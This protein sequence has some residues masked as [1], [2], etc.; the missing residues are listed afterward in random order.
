MSVF[1]LQG[2]AAIELQIGWHENRLLLSKVKNCGHSLTLHETKQRQWCS[3]VYICVRISLL[4]D[5]MAMSEFY[6]WIILQAANCFLDGFRLKVCTKLNAKLS[7]QFIWLLDLVCDANLSNNIYKMNAFNIESD[8]LLEQLVNTTS[9]VLTVSTAIALLH[10]KLMYYKHNQRMRGEIK[11][12][13][14]GMQDKNI[15]YSHTGWIDFNK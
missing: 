3:C 4:N 5:D 6:L 10:I 13:S 7:N 15:L 12:Q 11:V 1:L 2:L 14:R 9:I 8:A